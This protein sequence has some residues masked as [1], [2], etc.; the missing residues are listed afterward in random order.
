[1]SQFLGNL[2]GIGRTQLGVVLYQ[3]MGRTVLYSIVLDIYTASIQQERYFEIG[4]LSGNDPLDFTLLVN[5]SS[6]Y[7]DVTGMIFIPVAT[8][9]GSMT[10]ETRY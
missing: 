6:L 5:G 10:T 7:F 3:V 2:W 8:V 4:P 1:M 9:G